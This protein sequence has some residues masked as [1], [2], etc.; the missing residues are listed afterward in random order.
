MLVVIETFE[1]PGCISDQVRHVFPANNTPYS[2]ITARYKA[3]DDAG[4]I[5]RNGEKRPGESGN[6]QLVMRIT[7][8]GRSALSK[9]IQGRRSASASRSRTLRHQIIQHRDKS[10]VASPLA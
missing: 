6:M 10:G 4:Y 9:P 5:R 8:L 3:L 2:T 7:P 1:N